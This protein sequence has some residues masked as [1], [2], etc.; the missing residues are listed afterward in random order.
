MKLYLRDCVMKIQNEFVDV[1][2]EPDDLVLLFLRTGVEQ[3]HQNFEKIHLELEHGE[4]NFEFQNIGELYRQRHKSSVI[5]SSNT[6][7]KSYLVLLQLRQ[8]FDEF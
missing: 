6:Q 7:I 4:L 5:S 1:L 2:T 8:G 3:L